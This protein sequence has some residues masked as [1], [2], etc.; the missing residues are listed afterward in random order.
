MR[1]GENRGAWKECLA[2]LP[3]GPDAV[4][5]LPPPRLADGTSAFAA[6]RC[7]GQTRPC[8]FDGTLHSIRDRS[9]MPA[10]AVSAA[11]PWAAAGPVSSGLS[12]TSLSACSGGGGGGV[13]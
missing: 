3:P 12:S 9:R 8:A 7:A 5:T 11:P 2:L 13:G 1:P 10:A 6:F 4:H